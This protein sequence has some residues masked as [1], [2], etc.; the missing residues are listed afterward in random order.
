MVDYAQHES[1]ETPPS[2][3]RVTYRKEDCMSEIW[4]SDSFIDAARQLLPAEQLQR[5][6]A[7]VI[8][9]TE[10]EDMRHDKLMLF[11][12]EPSTGWETI[13][14][15]C[16]LE[17]KRRPQSSDLLFGHVIRAFHA[18][19]TPIFNFDFGAGTVLGF[20]ESLVWLD[21]QK[22]LGE[23]PLDRMVVSFLTDIILCRNGMLSRSWKAAESGDYRAR[24]SQATKSYFSHT[25]M[26]GTFRPYVRNLLLQ[27]IVR[28]FRIDDKKEDGPALY[29]HLF[30]MGKQKTPIGKLLIED[31][32]Y[33]CFSQLTP[34]GR[35]S[36]L[37]EIFER[38][39]RDEQEQKRPLKKT[40]SR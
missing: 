4:N 40:E 6:K 22:E 3:E 39:I 7:A 19:A 15:L 13:S 32:S 23:M 10:A 12:G 17:T 38:Q 14:D 5:A 27:S 9:A 34:Y 1:A 11:F 35:A 28:R 18:M 29:S 21:T 16:L 36:Y 25:H 30:D 26:R 8:F 31:L 2:K 37:V 24:L 33:G 20:L